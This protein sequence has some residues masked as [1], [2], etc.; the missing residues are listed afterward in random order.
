MQS[1]I[2]SQFL[3]FIYFEKFWINGINFVG[4]LFESSAIIKPGIKVKED[5]HLL[6]SKKFQWIQLM[7]ALG[8]FW[9]KSIKE[10]KT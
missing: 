8:A 2:I 4:N 3:G 5:L 9:N 6:E 1:T 10:N 7:N